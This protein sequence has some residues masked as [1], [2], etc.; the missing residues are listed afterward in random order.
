MPA[1]KPFVACCQKDGTFAADVVRPSFSAKVWREPGGGSGRR[2][3]TVPDTDQAR[4]QEEALPLSG[5]GSLDPL[6]E[7]IGDAMS[8]LA[9]RRTVLPSTTRYATC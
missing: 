1:P 8:C 3:V 7:R 2:D 5:P 6:I 9:K 4:I